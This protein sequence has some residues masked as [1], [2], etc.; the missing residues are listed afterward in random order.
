MDTIAEPARDV[1]VAA[2][3]DLCVVGGSCTGVFAAV[4]A[5]WLAVDRGTAVAE[6]DPAQLRRTL[7]RQGALII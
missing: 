6:V 3:V 1:P 5:A 4:T 2:D 7:Q